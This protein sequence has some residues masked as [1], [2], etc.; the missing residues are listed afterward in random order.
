MCPYCGGPM[1]Y[2]TTGQVSQLLGVSKK[3]VRKY[4]AQGRFPG[5]ETIYDI[6]TRR[7]FRIP[8]TAVM[9]LVKGM[10]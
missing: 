5:T 10:S 2:L 6:H 8:A 9:P 1:D 7:I 4:I 3:T